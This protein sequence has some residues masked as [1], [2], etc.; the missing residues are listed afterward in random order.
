MLEPEAKMTTRSRLTS[1]RGRVDARH[2]ASG[3][4]KL[5]RAYDP[6]DTR[7]GYRV[8]VERLWPRGLAKKR[9]RLDEWLKE[10]A[11]SDALRRWYG[12]D[13]ARFTEFARRY[14]RE[15]A[16]AAAQSLL[17]ALVVRA[18]RGPVTLVFSTHD[19]ELSNARVLERVLTRRLRVRRPKTR[20]GAKSPR[21]RAKSRPGAK[22]SRAAKLGPRHPGT[23]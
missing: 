13:P 22:S 1:P 16:T 15:L 3:L 20:A 8:L 19:V 18:K 17:G 4:L 2:E 12:H 5:K 11:P 23:R 14:R 10:L 6:A 7:D 21:A 9:A